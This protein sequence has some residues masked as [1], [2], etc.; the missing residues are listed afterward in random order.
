MSQIE[1][2]V[3]VIIA[4]AVIMIALTIMSTKHSRYWWR[5]YKNLDSL[6]TTLVQR[7]LQA[8]ARLPHVSGPSDVATLEAVAEELEGCIVTGDGDLL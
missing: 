2:L 5:K 4:Q 1:V 8:L 6:H 7:H 3:A